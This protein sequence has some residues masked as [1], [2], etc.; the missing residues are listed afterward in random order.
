MKQA[1]NTTTATTHR[2]Q[3][4]AES[5][6]VIIFYP[7]LNYSLVIDEISNRYGSRPAAPIA[8]P[9]APPS[10]YGWTIGRSQLETREITEIGVRTSVSK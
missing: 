9:G 6:G 3:V 2:R 1:L 5:T 7:P 4:P 10:Q 8:R